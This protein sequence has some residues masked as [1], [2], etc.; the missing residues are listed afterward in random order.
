M[1]DLSSGRRVSSTRVGSR[2]RLSVAQEAFHMYEEGDTSSCAGDS[3]GKSQNIY[4]QRK[5]WAQQ[6]QFLLED[7]HP[8]GSPGTTPGTGRGRRASQVSAAAQ[9]QP[10]ADQAA[11]Q[12]QQ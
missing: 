6:R 9:S 10:Q 11:G 4:S 8:H 2:K 5:W 3:T 7:L 1:M 12:Q